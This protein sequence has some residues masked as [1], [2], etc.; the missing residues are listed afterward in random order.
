MDLLFKLQDKVKILVKAYKEQSLLIN[1]LRSEISRME[2]IHQ[3]K[4]QKIEDLQEEL[5]AWKMKT[6][7]E[8]LATDK[9]IALQ[10][11]LTALIKQIDTY[12]EQLK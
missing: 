4:T 3:A 10:K 9:K 1:K 7:V 11:E 6:G 12:I 2:D 8:H 5:Y